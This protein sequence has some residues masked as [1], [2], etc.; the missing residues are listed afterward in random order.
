MQRLLETFS[1]DP[2]AHPVGQVADDAGIVHVADGGMVQPTERFRLPEK[3]GPRGG[4]G[5]EVHPE[6]DP[7]LQHLVVGLEENLL[8]R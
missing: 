7:A 2:V 3:P 4:L 5:V 1:F 8:R 6:A